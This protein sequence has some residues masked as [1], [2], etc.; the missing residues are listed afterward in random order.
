[1]ASADAG[2]E[3]LF[4]GQLQTYIMGS[5]ESAQTMCRSYLKL[6]C[7]FV[8][9]GESCLWEQLPF[10]FDRLNLMFERGL[11]LGEEMLLSEERM[12]AEGREQASRKV[13]RLRLLDQY[14]HQKNKDQF[15]AH[16]KEITE[17][18]RDSKAMQTGLSLEIFYEMTAIFITHI[19]RLDLF[20]V[21]S[22]KINISKLLS[23]A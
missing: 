8:A 23:I 16:F 5:L 3:P 9:T 11:G 22:G 20:H 19:N 4:R 13:R 21:L 7:S 18:L 17:A 6:V 2:S 14:L 15:D 1:R 10:K 12:F